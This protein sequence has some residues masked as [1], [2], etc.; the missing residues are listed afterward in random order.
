M[1]SGVI[2]GDT[3]GGFT[4]A[5]G[6]EWRFFTRTCNGVAEVQ[7]F[8]V[9]SGRDVGKS[10]VSEVVKRLPKPRAA[11]APPI[12]KMIVNFETWFGVTPV[13]PVSVDGSTLTVSATLTATPNHIELNT[14]TTI[15][16]DTTTIVCDL[17][18]SIEYPANGCTWTPTY[19]SVPKVTG[20]ED[21]RYHGSVTIIWD[22]AWTASDG[23]SGTFQQLRT[24]T[25]MLTMVLEIQTL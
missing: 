10:L 6:Q 22:L 9:V 17:W 18:G 12:D 24:T 4:D 19:P 23:T 11:F 15:W 20:T 21:L 2:G 25:P 14:G 3:I 8:P 13:N 16:G 7:P 1:V 5:S